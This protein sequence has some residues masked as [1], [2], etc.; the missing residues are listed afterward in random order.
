L[1]LFE[2]KEINTKVNYFLYLRETLYVKI[3]AEGIDCLAWLE[4]CFH[5]A[6]KIF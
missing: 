2:N 4:E 1:R 5:T 6:K 3:V